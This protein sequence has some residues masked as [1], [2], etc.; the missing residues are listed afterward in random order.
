MSKWMNVTKLF[1]AAMVIGF[2]GSTLMAKDANEPNKPKHKMREQQRSMKD[3]VEMRLEVMTKN[4]DLTKAQQDSIKPILQDETKQMQALRNDRALKPE[5][6]RAK[7]QEIRKESMAKIEA[8]LTPEQKEKQKKEQEMR[9][10]QREKM[11]EKR[12]EHEKGKVHDSNSR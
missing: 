5:Q 11:Q 1:V 6:R 4:L 2:C 8:Q 10:E 9:K 12:A 3:P 7:V